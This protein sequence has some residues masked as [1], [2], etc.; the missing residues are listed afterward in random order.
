VFQIL[1]T[2]ARNENN[3]MDFY[4]E[5]YVVCPGAEMWKAD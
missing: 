4:H 1:F 3:M 5:I 2:T